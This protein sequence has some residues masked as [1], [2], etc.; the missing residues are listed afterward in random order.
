RIHI[1]LEKQF[2]VSAPT[3]YR[4]MHILGLK[5]WLRQKKRMRKSAEIKKKNV[6]TGFIVGW[7]LSKNNDLRLYIKTW[8]TAEKYRQ[9]KTKMIVHSDNGSQ[10]TAEWMWNYAKKHNILI[11]VSCPGNSL[12]NATCET[13]FSQ[14]VHENPNLEKC[15]SFD[16]LSNLI[17]KYI[18][19]YNYNRITINLKCPPAFVYLL[20]IKEK[21]SL[22]IVKQTSLS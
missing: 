11:S 5:L 15:D 14:L 4:Y 10:Y 1:K 9:L 7:F 20:S 12:D 6:A 22:L 13:F 21:T 17:D 8:K 16:S 19:Y 2:K 18:N 3:I